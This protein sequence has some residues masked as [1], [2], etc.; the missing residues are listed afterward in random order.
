M[1]D[2]TCFLKGLILTRDSEITKILSNLLLEKN[3]IPYVSSEIEELT[4]DYCLI[5]IGYDINVYLVFEKLRNFKGILP[6]MI[7]LENGNFIS[8]NL[9]YISCKCKRIP[10][11]MGIFYLEHHI[12]EILSM[13]IY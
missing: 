12:D 4:S 3:I 6:H 11:P 5:I 8:S 7:F 9:P 1:K 10:L 13:S 2:T